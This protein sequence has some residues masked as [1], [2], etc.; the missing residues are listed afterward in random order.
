MKIQ[1]FTYQDYLKY[2]EILKIVEEINDKK[3]QK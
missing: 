3:M 1:I 2:Q